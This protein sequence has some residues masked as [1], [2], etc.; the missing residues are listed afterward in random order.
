MNIQKLNKQK[1][2]NIASKRQNQLIT[3]NHRVLYDGNRR[4]KY[5]FATP[6]NLPHKL[7][8]PTAGKY[9]PKKTIKI[10]NAFIELI[11]W[12]ITEGHF[13][14]DSNAI[15]ITQAEWFNKEKF[16]EIK[17]VLKRLKIKFTIHGDK[18][19]NSIFRICAESG[20]EI[21]KHISSKNIPRWC[22]NTISLEQMNLLLDTMMKGDGTISKNS[23]C[24]YVGDKKLADEFQE[25]CVKTDRRGIISDYKKETGSYHIVPSRRHH[26]E[27]TKHNVAETI[28]SGVVWCPTVNNGTWIARRNGKPFITGNSSQLAVNYT[29]DIFEALDLQD[30]VQILYT[31]GTVIHL[32]AG[33]QI[34]DFQTVKALVRKVCENYHLPYFTLTPTFSVCPAHGYVAGEHYK[35]PKCDMSC[36]VYSRVVGFLRPVGQWNKGKKEEFKQRKTFAI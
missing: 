15:R 27:I 1:M 22:L 25:L 20:K 12:I 9:K 24:Y 21:R 29:D 17:E 23:S 13:E 8:I 16:D 30:D 19:G 14:A 34:K 11:G 31:G 35:C 3:P 26:T 6:K 32:F 33:E 28:Y 5:Q 2:Y 18:R 4:G 36:E 7:I 10:S